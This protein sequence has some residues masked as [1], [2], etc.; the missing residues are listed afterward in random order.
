MQAP[1][2]LGGASHA[3]GDSTGSALDGWEL[4]FRGHPQLRKL[5]RKRREAPKAPLCG[6]PEIA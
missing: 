6:V 5:A 1:P 2:L 3:L 4:G